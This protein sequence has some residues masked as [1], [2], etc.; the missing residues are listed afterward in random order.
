MLST[1]LHQTLIQTNVYVL[2]DA[3]CGDITALQNRKQ[4][5]VK[6]WKTISKTTGD[7][8]L[9]LNAYHSFLNKLLLI[10]KIGS[11]DMDGNCS[12]AESGG[13]EM[14]REGQE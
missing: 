1:N 8:A 4:D 2:T 6:M 7:E 11:E 9:L 5:L 14:D 10:L 3:L 12:P 13:S